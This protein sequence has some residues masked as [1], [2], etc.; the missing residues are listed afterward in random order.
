MSAYSS[1]VRRASLCLLALALCVAGG[2]GGEPARSAWC[3]QVKRG[4]AQFDTQRPLDA[5][6]LAEYDAI[7]KQAPAAI[8]RDVLAVRD[9]AVLFFRSDVAFRTNP[10][11][12]T[13]FVRAAG[14]V[15]RY[16]RSHCGADIP[17][18]HKGQN[19]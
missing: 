16:L 2:C 19:A 3:K 17:L 13:A 10:A 8:R 9:G 7:A 12:V 6:A 15:D 1:G 4:H 11:R 5:R 18:P 14:R